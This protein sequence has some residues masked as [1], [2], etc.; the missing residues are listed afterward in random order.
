MW[1][2]W[3]THRPSSKALAL[4]SRNMVIMGE[5]VVSWLYFMLFSFIMFFYNTIYFNLV[6]YVMGLCLFILG[7]VFTFLA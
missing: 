7:F 4:A 3:G 5:P 6:F 2:S 1:F